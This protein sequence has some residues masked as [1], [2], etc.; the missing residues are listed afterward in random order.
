[1]RKRAIGV[2]A[3][4]CAFTAVFSSASASASASASV[5][6]DVTEVTISALH[7]TQGMPRSVVHVYYA[8]VVGRWGF[9][10]FTAGEGGGDTIMHQVNGAWKVLGQGHG[11]MDHVI[12]VAF[13]VPPEIA[14]ALL[15]GTCPKA[16]RAALGAGVTSTSVAVRRTAIV[17][18][19][20]NHD[21]TIRCPAF[22][23]R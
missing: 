4:I 18:H 15:Q 19:G 23:S 3:V 13:G 20:R 11:Q 1:M 2:F 9:T 6:D 14:D 12:L 22:S 21:T 17:G 16:R 10:S 8:S 5:Q 7:K